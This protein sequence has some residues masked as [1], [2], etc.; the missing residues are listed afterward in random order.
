MR[1][2]V[3]CGRRGM[4]CLATMTITPPDL[5]LLLGSGLVLLGLGWRRSLQ[6]AL[7]RPA[8]TS[9]ADAKVPP[10]TAA[11]SMPSQLSRSV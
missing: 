3:H 4:V 10:S 2:S 11:A 1:L 6:K 7:Q 9:P 5:W 8:A